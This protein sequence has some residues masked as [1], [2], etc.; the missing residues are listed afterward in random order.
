MRFSHRVPSLALM[1]LI[2]ACGGGGGGA[3]APAGESAAAE[4]SAAAGGGVDTANTPSPEAPAAAPSEAPAAGGGG[5][6]LGVCELVT[7]DELRGIFGVE[8]SLTLFAG[9][10]D[11]CDIQSADGAPLGATVLT[12]MS[13]LSASAVFDAYAASPGAQDI[14]GIGDKAAYDPTQAVL[15]VLKADK[16]LT[17]AVFED[18]TRDEAARLELMKQIASAAAGRM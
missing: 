12:A 10:P 11:T 5:T 13:G 17:V 4:P 14:P 15:V 8:V 3:A 6:A 1:F 7:E 9:P 18:G 2:A 16:L